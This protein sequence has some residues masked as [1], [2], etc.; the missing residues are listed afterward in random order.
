MDWFQVSVLVIA[1]AVIIGT[2]LIAAI[3]GG[4]AQDRRQGQYPQDRQD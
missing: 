1:F 2:L 3:G 4:H